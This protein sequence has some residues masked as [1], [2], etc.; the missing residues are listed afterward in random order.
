MSRLTS[1]LPALSRLAL[2][3]RSPFRPGRLWRPAILMALLLGIVG[4]ALSA[5]F[6]GEPV[7]YAQDEDSD[8]V[9]LGLILE[10]PQDS[11]GELSHALNIIVVNN[12]SRSAYDVEVVVKVEYPE[13][14][15]RFLFLPDV[16]IGE[17]SLENNAYSLRWSIPALGELQ[18]EEIT[19]RIYHRILAGHNVGTTFDNS[20]VPHEVSGK[21]TTASFDRNLGN[22]TARVWSYRYH[23]D[24]TSQIQAEGNYTV[25]VSVDEASPSPGDTVNFTITAD[26]DN[27]IRELLNVSALTPPPIDLKVDIGFTGG[28]SVSG[29]PSYDPSG[30]DKPDSVS[31]SNGVFNIGTLNMGGRE[32]PRYSVTLPISVASDAVVNEQC[33]T[34]TLT[35]NPPPG[36]GPRDDDIS[37]NVA[38][39]CLGELSVIP[40]VS[41]QVDAFTIYPCVGD[42]NS[43]CDN[44]DDVRVRAVNKTGQP[45]TIFGSGNAVVHVRDRPNRNYDSHDNSVNAGTKVSW[46]IPVTW[47]ANKIDDIHTQWTNLRDGFAAGGTDGGSPPG[48]VHIRAFE[49]KSFEIIYKMTPD[50]TPPWTFED[51]VGYN[52]ASTNGPFIYVAEFEK[53][54]TY[55][56]EFTVKLTRPTLDGD[57]NCD[58]DANNVNQR[59]CATETYTFHVGPIADLEV[60]GGDVDS[61]AAAGRDAL[62]IL[63]VNNGPDHSLGA[64][65]SGLPAGADVFHI[66]QG[67]YDSSTGEWDIGELKHTDYRRSAGVP[68]HATLVL[69]ASVGDTADVSIANSENYEV[70]I[71][72][73]SNPVNLTHTTKTACEGVT[74]ASWNSTPVYDYDGSN[75]SATLA[76]AAGTGGGEGVPS[77][78]SATH[79]AAAVVVTWE[80]VELLHGV[81]VSHYEIEW[82]ADGSTSWT[83]LLDEVLGTRY[84]DTSLESGATRHYR[85]RAV[86]M[87]DVKGL[88]STPMGATA[89][90]PMPGQPTGL[91]ATVVSVSGVLLSWT[92]PTGEPAAASYQIEHSADGNSGWRRLASNVTTTSH[93]DSGVGFGVT[94]HYRVRAVSAAGQPG[95]WSDAAN[96]TT[97]NPAPLAPGNVT[98]LPNALN[99]IIAAWNP[100]S[101]NAGAAISHYE[102][103]WSADGNAPWA[104]LSTNVPG[105]SYVDA[106]ATAG[107]L[108][109]YRV[110]A[111]NATGLKSPWSATASATAATPML[112]AP[113]KP[114]GLTAT[115]STGSNLADIALAWN[116]PTGGVSAARYEIEYSENGNAPWMPLTNSVTTTSH[117]H[118]GAGYG[119]TRHYRVRAVNSEGLAGEWSDTDDATTQNP[120]P[121]APGNVAALPNGM[122][123]LIVAW[124]AADTNQGAPVSHYQI[125]W[126]A[127]G[128]EPWM[129]LAANV[130]G[131]RY[132]DTAPTAGTTR[133]Y[134]VLA[135][136]AN[137]L[138]SP[139][140]GSAS[141]TAATEPLAAPG[142][143]TGLSA[144]V[145]NV[146][147]ID[148]SWT[149]ATDGVPVGRYEI[150]YS[151]DG[152]TGW[153]PLANN[154]PST[155]RAYTDNGAGYGVTRHYRVR[156]VNTEELEGEW[157]DTANAITQNPT[158]GVPLNVM[159]VARGLTSIIV[160]WNP[161]AA[162]QG[163]PVTKYEVEV[164]LT[165]N[166]PWPSEDASIISNVYTHSGLSANDTRHY[167]VYAYNDA[168]R[169]N[170]S[171]VVTVTIPTEL[172]GATAGAPGVP[173]VTATPNGRTEIVLRWNKPIEN[174][175]PIISYDVEIA[176]RRNGPWTDAETNL[177]GSATSWTHTGLIGS[178]TKWY[179]VQAEN[180]IDKGGWSES[181][182]AT[183]Q[184]P[185]QADAP[186]NLTAAPDGDSAIDLSWSPPPDDGGSPITRYELQWSQ[187]GTERSWRTEG[188]TPD[189]ETRTYKDTGLSFGTTRYY[190]VAARNSVT[191]GV[192]SAPVSTTTLSG[193]PGIP[194]LTVRATDAN[195][196]A[197][198]WTVPADN[199]DPITGYE[200]E[201]SE[202]GT[203]DSWTAL[204]NPGASDTSHDDSGL[205]PGTRRYYQ[206]RAVNNTG[207]GSW[208]TARNAVTPPDVPTA[209]TLEAE[210]NGQN[211]I[212]LTWEEPET[213]GAPISRYE[214]QVSTDGGTN[215]SRLTTPSASTRSYTHSRLQPGDGRHYQLRA[216]NRA[217]W[218]E[219]SQPASATTLTGVPAAPGLTARSSGS[220]EIKLS[221]TKPDDRG[222]DIQVYQIHVSEDGNDWDN[223]GGNLPAIDTE[224]VHDGLS[225][226]STRHYRIRAGNV[227]G[228]GQWSSTRS[229]RTD[230]GG[231]DAPVLTASE[232]GEN[233][234][235]LSWTIPAN[236]GSAIRGYWVERSVDGAAPWERLT[237]S[238]R[239]TT[240]SDTSLYRGMKRYYRVAA[241]NGAGTGPYSKVESATTG[242]PAEAPSAPML[243]RFSSVGRN[244]LTIA[245]DPPTN[246]GGA[247]ISGYE[248]EVS[249][250]CGDNPAPGCGFTGDD[251]KAT[252]STSARISGLNIDGDHFLRVRAVNPVG[253]GAWAVELRA[254]L[255]PSMNGQVRV[256]PTTITVD[257]GD[258]VR[259]TV[260]LSTA[261]PHPTQLFVQTHGSGDSD[262]LEK[263]AFVYTGS[264]LI[265]NG[266]THPRDDDWS[267]FAYN[268]NTGVSVS[269]TAPEDDDALD[270]IA[271]MEHYVIAVPYGNYRP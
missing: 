50:T 266:W 24:A 100:A 68:E 51:T 238:N 184:A 197:L 66:S 59:F 144:S 182:S 187:D 151:A 13:D 190:R 181:V 20:L 145:S 203:A 134:R 169:G 185:G 213:R 127:D 65:V 29:T 255:K 193:V 269:F 106:T 86:S 207:N 210:V 250:P 18:R 244:Q 8:Y 133:H 45:G 159:A 270:D 240:Y 136:N 237:S 205:D 206:V 258:T 40:L 220:S 27:P 131:T 251:I 76:A 158:P 241:T 75:N 224:Y 39:L 105:T 97:E 35:G 108:R 155:T 129:I 157:S 25:A 110:L 33:L 256:S 209:P 165:G 186:V 64:Q 88:W 147:D 223:L 49:D 132:I 236:N 230:A 43:P 152:S 80:A 63:A 67:S 162:Y 41:S 248:Y 117:T 109:H 28:L 22:N 70:C 262:D 153:Q 242:E 120:A 167:R 142:K 107:S 173:V 71:G 199:G 188:R 196:I 174:G 138:S 62:T 53:L 177:G 141:A 10:F 119:V 69:S 201:W 11:H 211:A 42:T 116:A 208:S 161:P 91:A 171:S 189:A 253:K 229:A 164:S 122:M 115:A 23:V 55:K 32:P 3:H 98:A 222:S 215:Y 12:G 166:A 135:V 245:W 9:D 92:A 163:K 52:P 267:D 96:A 246:N 252:T 191:L 113:G 74:N 56:V 231:P 90:L 225:G 261:P 72:P 176:D 79:G 95:A 232:N 7:A 81:P 168:G 216:Q 233:Q 200:I 234:I 58:P 38:K 221:W 170:A 5:A 112:D 34:A 21:V 179:R 19:P 149:G 192:W 17:A 219:W 82:S 89:A 111:V 217:G 257:E 101:V 4:A 249:H 123:G 14:S 46:Q 47:N 78:A 271:V 102:V 160:S 143:P 85:V 16:S 146:S 99:G 195:T 243:P 172:Q 73:K 44:T 83:E 180:H 124:D 84:V 194:R 130:T 61:H 254:T 2:H 265:P 31:Y 37:D 1:L 104:P 198:T 264:V 228:E 227:N 183:T 114:M 139:W 87:A 26:R 128:S 30:D 204:T 6:L 60:R 77:M 263:G 103:E 202:D 235:D 36:T 148:L 93:L 48:R 137:G 54:G 247:P 154:I 57:E 214:I 239:T 94:R 268:W 260:R 175:S 178:T 121:L 156:A 226:G 126:S 15:S 118:S 259:Y 150:E 125:E 218:S 140:S 212:D